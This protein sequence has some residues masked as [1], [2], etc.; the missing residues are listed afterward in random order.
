[1]STQKTLSG[2]NL[3]SNWP[4]IAS[5]E[6]E[7]KGYDALYDP[8]EDKTKP[9][10]RQHIDRLSYT[11]KNGTKELRYLAVQHIFGSEN[12]T[13][14]Q[15]TALKENFKK[16]KPQIIL[17]EGPKLYENSQ[18]TEEDAYIHGEKAYVQYLVQ[19]H[20]K[21]L[22]PREK[23]VIMKPA[24]TPNEDE[25]AEYR[26]RGYSNEEI[27]TSEVFKWMHYESSGV[28]N[29]PG[30]TNEQ[31]TQKIQELQFR[32]EANPLAPI[33]PDFFSLVPRP[34]GHQWTADLIK[35]EI[36]KQAG[37]PLNVDFD[38][39]TIPRFK[40][41]YNTQRVFRDQYIIRK[42]AEICQKYDTVM[43]VMGS[44]H[45]IRDRHSLEQFFDI[46][47]N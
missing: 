29:T 9:P 1:M 31:K 28:K 21:N 2:N 37:R 17:Y 33:Y 6:E 19:E 39:L 32:Y 7:A 11:L 24:D 13:H 23:P 44:G 14:S 41:M 42:I 40:Q 36:R 43:V 22:K 16:S 8:G 4:Q 27:A 25:P 46:D 26:K 35:Q 3:P 12:R 45:A 18:I 38:Y 20:N 30:L 10:A 5:P 47:R 34:D 15:F